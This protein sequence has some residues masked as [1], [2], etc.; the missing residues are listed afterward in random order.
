MTAPSQQSD[1]DLIRR[2]QAGDKDAFGVLVRKYAGTATGSAYLLLKSHEDALDASQEA[3]VQAW[4]SIGRFDTAAAFFP[5]YA[6]ILRNLCISRLRRR[7]KHSTAEL[8]DGHSDDSP[9]ADPVLLAERGE[10]RDRVWQAILALSP[11]QREII[12]MSH[13]HDLTYRQMADAI[14]IPIGTVMSRLYNA[15]RALR[16]RLADDEP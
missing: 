14:G 2:C 10:R 1:A 9:E 6:T 3:F 4:R 5:W 15:R 13:F 8:G 7:P 16:E 11:Q 12:V